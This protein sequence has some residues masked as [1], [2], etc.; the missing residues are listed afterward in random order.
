M[1]AFY[2]DRDSQEIH[3]LIRPFLMAKPKLEWSRFDPDFSR[4]EVAKY[5][6]FQNKTLVLEL[7][8]RRIYLVNPTESRISEGLDRIL[9]PEITL[10]FLAGH[11]E[12]RLEEDLSIL[13]ERLRQAGF[14]L[15]TI[16]QI[17]ENALQ[18]LSALI[19]GNPRMPYSAD[20]IA[21]LHAFAEKGGRFVFLSE[22]ENSVIEK[23][24]TRFGLDLSLQ[25]L[26]LSEGGDA[27]SITRNELL[28][29]VLPKHDS[30]YWS[31]MQGMI[32]FYRAAGLSIRS[33]VGV[34]PADPNF[35]LTPL[36]LAHHDVEMQGEKSPPVMAEIRT[37][38]F[39]AIVVGD[40]DWLRN[41]FARDT[42]HAEWFGH[43]LGRFCDSE[44]RISPPDIR[45][46]RSSTWITQAE[47]RIWQAILYLIIPFISFSA[48]LRSFLKRREA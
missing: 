42:R 46:T 21:H 25:P 40:S 34:A 43:L 8:R 22:A 14:Y 35:L 29:P 18:G 33:S 41:D 36:M 2:G 3:A 47:F 12:L 13:G 9:R 1:I 37:S 44:V 4:V 19:I 11:Q 48:W 7:G 23:L 28:I 45:L 26:L 31:D 39:R 10:A 17:S 20:E 38:N 16:D 24:F 30:P 6:I 5:G 15:H 27:F 32:L